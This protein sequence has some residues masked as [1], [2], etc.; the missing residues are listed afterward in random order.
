MTLFSKPTQRPEEQPQRTSQGGNQFSPVNDQMRQMP[1]ARPFAP[2]A[3]TNQVGNPQIPPTPTQ[4]LTPNPARQ[5]HGGSQGLGPNPANS[6]LGLLQRVKPTANT[7]APAE[8]EGN[9]LILHRAQHFLL[10]T[11]YRPGRPA[12][13]FRRPTGHTTTMPKVMPQQGERI[14]SSETHM[15]P[16]LS[17]INPVNTK[18]RIPIPRWLEAIIVM[19]VLAVGG[20]AHTLNMFN[21]PRYEL[22]EGTYMSSAFAILHGQLW[23]YA[24]GYGHP[25]LAWMQIAAWVQLTGGFFT[26]GNAINSGRVLMLLYSLASALLVYLIVRRFGASRSAGLLSMVIFALSPLSITY[27]RQVLLDNVA[28]FWLLVSLYLLV[29]GNSRLVYIALSAVALGISFLSKEVFVLFMPGMVYA[30]WLHTTQFQRK[31]AIVAFAYTMLAVAS[32][33]VLLAL[34]KGE[35]FPQ[36]FFPWDHSQHLSLLATFIGQT[37]RT[38]SQGSFAQS[39][40]NWWY[41]DK[42]LMAAGI[43]AIAFNL[44]VGWWNRKQL[45]LA[46]LAISFWFLLIRGG[47]VLSFYLIPLIPLLAI[48]VAMAIHTM[49][50]WASRL[51]HFDLVRPLL[52][53]GVIAAIVPYD[54]ANAGVIYTQHPTSAQDQAITWVRENVPHNDFIVINSY[55]YMDLRAPNG[56]GVS[57]GATYPYAHVYQ[58]V[59]TDPAIKYALLDN[60]YDRIDY[61]IADSGMLSDIQ[62]QPALYTILSKALNSSIVRATFSTPD[63]NNDIVITIYEVKHHN[64]Q[65]VVSTAP[66]NSGS[67]ST[68]VA[69]NAQGTTPMDRRL[70]IG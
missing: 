39:F 6:G 50:N 51:V 32:A 55:L 52:I 10:R 37:Q 12:A 25:P 62:T 11:A 66:S 26:F 29:V 48:N 7:Q 21:Y 8:I 45:L 30:V 59:A 65:P 4:P 69:L 23:P 2:A 9:N 34:L 35:L 36:D 22:D 67:S 43:L 49:A 3:P 16:M 1:N 42:L 70:Y 54:M 15:M 20:I 40:S 27:Q 53:F 44:L 58:N 17:T 18:G 14:A 5:N 56:I 47:V 19:I 60:N 68:N 31:F 28:T 24:Y 46:L 38:Q 41:A 64:P 61:I 33:F 63:G 13:P 57:D